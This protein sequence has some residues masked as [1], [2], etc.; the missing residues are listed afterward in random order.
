MDV[1]FE[2]NLQGLFF[3]PFTRLISLEQPEFLIFA[4]FSS[5]HAWKIGDAKRQRDF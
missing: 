4:Q 2:I 5:S 1:K 3:F